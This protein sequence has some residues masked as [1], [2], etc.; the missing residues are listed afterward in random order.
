MS[1]TSDQ[2]NAS[3]GPV[4]R[5]FFAALRW[6]R[7][8]FTLIGALVTLLPILF[9]FALSRQQ[10]EMLEA[11][12]LKISRDKPARLTLSLW[13]SLAAGEPDPT[14][15]LFTR[16][17]RGKEPVYL[18]EVRAA[19]RRA[20]KDDRVSQLSLNI[21]YL[22]GS[23]TDFTELHRI[24]TEFRASGKKVS[25]VL[26]QGD[27]WTYYVASAAN[28]VVL[29]PAS[30]L[31]LM[32]PAFHLTYFGEG[33]KKLGVEIDVVRAGKYKSAFEPFVLN[34]PSEPT[35]E[36]YGALQQSL[37]DFLVQEVS[38]G[39]EQDPA[40]VLGWYKK[41][42]YTA[43][44]AKA[45]GMIDGIGYDVDGIYSARRD[46]KDIV[47]VG[48]YLKFVRA[49]KEPNEA[50]GDEGIALIE[51]SGE[52]SM[53]APEGGFSGD[54]E[55]I[56]PLPMV[57]ELR[58]AMDEDDVKAV[59]FRVDSPGGSA[60]ASDIIWNYVD[61]L[62]RTKPVV[63][64]MGTYAAS[65]GY[66]IS[67]PAKKIVAEATTITGSIGVI[68]MLPNF[69]AFEEKYGV[70][71]HVVTS[72]DRKEMMNMGSKATPEDKA[73][74]DGTIAQVYQEF[75]A[76]V[77]RGRNMKVE[78]V[79]RLAQGRVYTGL[80]AK[81]LGLVDEIGGIN[82]AFREAKILAGFDPEKLYP[83]LHYEP[84]DM[85]LMHC[86]KSTKKMMKCLKEAE[87][88]ISARLF[89]PTDEQRVVKAARRW[90]DVA[91][92]ERTLALWPGYFG[93]GV[94]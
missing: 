36:E 61:Q 46:V 11:P 93:F 82:T 16:L 64:S 86:L 50:G 75:L 60:I 65:G 4:A 92:K 43:E 19:M 14:S 44:Q 26:T 70:S 67:A 52:I 22:G 42:I 80:Q 32:G 66:Y 47:S 41:S 3:R 13:G 6:I 73:L 21:G 49:E 20:A 15:R 56:A 37:R 63:V 45:E 40:K 10:A 81:A 83:V 55:G 39:R 38:K 35:L 78:D 5:F 33:L 77:A 17:F 76:K 79:D 51:A 84:E 91:A 48:D 18:P 69:R 72:S 94:R 31:E 28:T 57:E 23:M 9:V 53:A 90:L 71:F 8:Y 25:A 27:D 30:P 29:N 74:V 12:D 62:A 1:T 89:E 68:G 59:V 34:K 85:S 58:W 2:A 7:N 54:D 88:Q 24:I 87:G